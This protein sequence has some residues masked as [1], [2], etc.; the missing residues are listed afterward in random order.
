MEGKTGLWAIPL[1]SCTENE[2]VWNAGQ[3]SSCAQDK[4]E[5]SMSDSPPVNIVNE[6]DTAGAPQDKRA[7]AGL[8]GLT[9][10]SEFKQKSI[11]GS[12]A[13]L[14]G[15]VLNF[16]VQMGS[17]AILAR[18]LSPTDYGLQ[19]MVFTLTGFFYLVQDAGLSVATV[20]TETLTEAQISTLFWINC[21][22]GA[23]LTLLISAMGPFMVIFYKDPRLLWVTVVS[24]TVFVLNGIIVQHRAL[25]VRAMRFTALAKLDAV[26]L[27]LSTILAIV[28][29]YYGFGYWAL[30]GRVVA[31]TI[32]GV[33]GVFILMPWVPGKPRR[34]TGI[35]SMVK[36]GGTVT[37]NSFVVF[38][39]Y[40]TEK[41]L[42]GR[43]WGA[44]PLGL[45]GR[46]YQLAN[47]PVQQ[48]MGAVGSVAF[49]VLS[50]MQNDLDR[51]RRSYLKFHS[52]VV[53][54]TV[55]AV[56]CC[57]LFADEIIHALLG[58]KWT[59]AA[60]VLRLLS[61]TVMAFALINPLS[62]LLKATGK[63]RRSLNIALLIAPVVILGVV[64]GLRYGP[65]GVAL[66]YS[67]A[68][69]LLSVPLVAWAIHR[70]GVSALDYWNCIKPAVVAGAVG[71]VAGWLCKMSLQASLT[72]LPQLIVESTVSLSI[73]AW[74]LLYVMGQKPVYMDL[75]ANL[76]Q[77]KVVE[78]PA[79]G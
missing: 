1:G 62:W 68:M 42:L 71:G 64:A 2:I 7:K 9:P 77:R 54:M 73:Y 24:A 61:P 43:F 44:A 51:L 76:F 53:S 57:S 14:L 58:P 70:T 18:L 47:L 63:V 34:G 16:A 32:M 38:M 41:I 79:E 67:V 39:A 8:Y 40:N 17:T 36:F 49:P 69:I 75:I 33:I 3:C 66:G 10:S 4:T 37:L 25:L 52:I 22:V 12:A 35:R 72:P 13:T 46:A 11:R 48:L 20:Q 19:G 29:A 31:G 28:M 23:A 45:Y 5:N 55:P 6:S 27:V 74:I 21:A 65:P 78:V 50:R 15:Q 59:G 30:V 56:I 26:V 60:G